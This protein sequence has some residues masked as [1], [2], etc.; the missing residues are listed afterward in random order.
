MEAS[1]WIHVLKLA[2]FVL[3]LLISVGSALWIAKKRWGMKRTIRKAISQIEFGEV[4]AGMYK[5]L[6]AESTWITLYNHWD[7]KT[8]PRAQSKRLV[9]Y[10]QVIAAVE[11]CCERSHVTLD[12]ELFKSTI[13]DLVDLLS[14][15]KNRTFGG[16]FRRELSPQY[17]QL[18]D[19]FDSQHVNFLAQVKVSQLTDVS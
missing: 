15:R 17:Q 8:K 18:H 1:N 19:E 4:A 5:L 13:D 7:G 16:E 9:E 12:V 11:I 6:E 3:C 10:G 2:I 14:N